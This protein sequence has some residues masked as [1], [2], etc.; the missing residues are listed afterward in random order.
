MRRVLYHD[1]IGSSIERIDRCDSNACACA[2]ELSSEVEVSSKFGALD[3][4]S[5]RTRSEGWLRRSPTAADLD[6]AFAGHRKWRRPVDVLRAG[7]ASL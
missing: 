2:I 6:A 7:T 1:G 5:D 3:S 4:S